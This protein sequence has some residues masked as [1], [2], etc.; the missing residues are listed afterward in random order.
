MDF[1]QVALITLIITATVLLLVGGVLVFFILKDTRKALTRLNEVL[2]GNNSS[3]I[4]VKQSAG[5]AQIMAPK[6]RK[7]Y[8]SRAQNSSPKRFFRKSS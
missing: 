2:Y 1:L 7:K 8:A 4:K 5:A 6:V 3:A